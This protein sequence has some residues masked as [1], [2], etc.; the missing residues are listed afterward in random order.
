MV[1]AS[2][3]AG[4]LLIGGAI[5]LHDAFTYTD[6]HVDRVP[7]NP[8][9]LHPETGGPKKLPVAKVLVSDEEDEVNKKLSTKPRLVIVGGG[10]GAMGILSSL[11]SGQYHVTLI[12]PE[13]FT[14]FTPLLPS[15]AVGTVQVR[16]LIEP[17]RK[18]VARLHGHYIAGKA[19][20]IVMSERLLE[21]ETTG[22]NGEKH[23]IYVPYDKLVIAV[24]STSTTHGVTGLE[25]TFQ[26]KTV[27]DAQAIRRRISDNF[28]TASLPTTTPE[29]R[30]RL[31]SFV[32]CGGGPTGVETAAEIYDLCQE[33]ILNYYPKLCREEVSISLIQSREHIL[34]TYSEAISKYA[35]NKF[36]RDGVNVIT[37]A[38]VKEIQRDRVIYTIK[39]GN[40]LVERE[41]PSNFVLWSTGIA[42]NPF[43]RRVSSLLP[44]QVHFKAI[45]VDAQLR[46]KG[47]PLGTVYAIGDASVLETNIVG[48][49]LELVDDAD[50]NHDGKI[51]LE[52]WKIMAAQIRKRMPMTENHLQKVRDLF[53]RYD[54][55]NDN[56]LDLNELAL[57]LQEISSKITPLPATAQVASQQGKYIGKK[58]SKLARQKDILAAND[59]PFTDE[60]V[61]GPFRYA[62]LGSLAYIGN[63]AVFDF[64]NR[65]FM[66]G[67]AAM[68]AWRS[69]YW[70]EQVSS[71]TR[72]LLM[73]DWIIRGIWGRDISRL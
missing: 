53:E 59:I 28:E 25:H 43:T 63:A 9:A 49:L 3:A 19:V 4:V 41:M 36:N 70:S 12:S 73:F 16:S 37:N 51:D 29:E 72:A 17:L 20:D 58:L 69:V 5:F 27:P 52:E 50:R 46:V 47:A 65:T 54:T 21:V 26:L 66:G 38:R 30:K 42:M 6:R 67:L 7:V 31:L 57:L 8:L 71:R 62:H 10:W 61:S 2:S 24:G 18:I 39:D 34:N 35:E 15:A 1:G 56:S 45:E 32:V 40:K 55:N 13:T 64:G 22:P 33:D 48:H 68:Y 11:Q 23:N 60:A 14:T 44:N